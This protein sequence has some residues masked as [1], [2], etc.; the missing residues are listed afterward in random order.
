MKAPPKK[1]H[2][3][4]PIL[5]GF[6]DGLKIPTGFLK[7]LKGHGCIEHAILRRA[8][9]KWLVKVKGWRLED[10]WKKFAEEL[11]LQLGE[12]LIFRHEGDMEFEVSIFDSS[13][14]EREYG[15]EEKAHTPE[16]TWKKFEFKDAMEKPKPNIMSLHKAFPDLEAA[17]DMLSDRPHLIST[18]KPHWIS[19]SLMHVPK[20][21]ARESGLSKRKCM[22]M[23]RDEQRSWAFRLH[24]SAGKTLIGGGWRK[25]CAANFL[26][27][28]DP[29][30]FE[31]FS[32]GEKPILKFY[33]LRGDASLQPEGKKTNLDTKRVSIQEKPNA[34][35][36]SS[37]KA[38]SHAK[39]SAQKPFGHSIFVCTIRPYCLTYGFLYIPKHFAYANGLIAN[40]KCGLIIKDEMQRSWNLRISSCKTQ[41]Y[42]GDGC[43]KFIADNC[44]KEG[45][46]IMFEVVTDGETPIWKFHVVTDAKTPM[47]KFQGCRIKTSDMTAP[48]LQVPASTSTDANPHFISTIKSYSITI[49]ALYL[50]MAFAK[51]T[52]LMNGRCEMI[53]IDGK[54][55]SWS[56]WLGP[57]GKHFGIKRGW[58]KFIKANGFRVGDTYKFELINN[59]KIPIAYVH[60]NMKQLVMGSTEASGC[61]VQWPER[62]DLT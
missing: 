59:G 27:E 10:G 50:P 36:K 40:K 24:Y 54:H 55:R 21:F 49:S 57:I 2:F 44:L 14:R 38:S 3:F 62:S 8:G 58:R 48:K 12:L 53:L 45:D 34:S 61:K 17:K 16:E 43:R 28:G 35:N 4:K 25:F 9:K 60:H 51:S 13:Q 7:Y 29:I 15:A 11:N 30:M 41:V 56:M 37:I 20:L 5:P 26:T 1:P 39:A 42:I 22:I 6:K 23:I 52:G 47:R 18:V 33:D 19:K 31:I 32:K 46:R